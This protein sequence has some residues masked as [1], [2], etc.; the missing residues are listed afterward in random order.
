MNNDQIEI[1]VQST[2]SKVYLN[3]IKT[4]EIILEVD[5]VLEIKKA[6]CEYILNNLNYRHELFL[7]TP[8]HLRDKVEKI[9]KRVTDNY[10]RRLKSCIQRKIFH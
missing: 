10:C 9:I 2:K 4:R 5:S 6:F 8:I 7:N 1:I 3:Y